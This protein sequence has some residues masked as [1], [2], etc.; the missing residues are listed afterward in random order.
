[1]SFAPAVF[2]Q[3]LVLRIFDATNAPLDVTQLQLPS[4]M[5]IG[6]QRTSCRRK[7]ACCLVCGPTGSG[8]N[9]DALFSGSL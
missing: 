9:H 1:M 5:L 2:G 4:S 7:P 8:Q 6:V 3:K